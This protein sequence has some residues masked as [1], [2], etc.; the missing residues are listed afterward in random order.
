MSGIN[1]FDMIS[2]AAGGSAVKQVSEKTGLPPEMAQMAIKAL[3]PAIAGGVQRNVQQPGGLEALLGALQ[4]GDH[5]RYLDNPETLT[6]PETIQDGNA[7]LGHLLGSKDTSRA[8]AAQA[9]QK[10]GIPPEVLKMLL[11][12]VASM[13]MASLSKQSKKP[14]L[15]SVLAG[16]VAG[17]MG[18]KGNSG[19]GG[20]LGGLLGGGQKQQAPAQGGLGG[21]LGSLLDADG[22]GN[23]MDDIFQMVMNRK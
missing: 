23:A 18:G 19:L 21:M 2:Q 22:D 13:A 9:S 20:M 8:V 10:T 7:I 5:A 4:K 1:M 3:L 6:Q 17:Q 12:I 15:A 11:P 16:A 14:D